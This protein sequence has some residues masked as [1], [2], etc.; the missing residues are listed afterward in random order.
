MVAALPAAAET[1][2]ARV[3][4][5]TDNGGQSPQVTVPIQ[6]PARSHERPP[7]SVIAPAVT[8]DVRAESGEEARVPDGTPPAAAS[9]AEEPAETEVPAEDVAPVVTP[10]EP[11]LARVEGTASVVPVGELEGGSRE[12]AAISEPATTAPA[13][14]GPVT[15]PLL[16]ALP[17]TAR[18]TPAAESVPEAVAEPTPTTRVAAAPDV[19]LTPLR[20]GDEVV[21]DAPA[22]DPE[23]RCAAETA[24]LNASLRASRRL[25]SQSGVSF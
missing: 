13:V 8:P 6:E 12:P 2:A 14:P 1:V 24:K 23:Q 21:Y 11:M 3:E 18:P 17:A 15:E 10:V 5:E 9:V 25:A 20:Q 4:E 19:E 16:A 7:R 22:R